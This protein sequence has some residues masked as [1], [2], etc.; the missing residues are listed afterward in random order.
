VCVTFP[1]K[2]LSM[3]LSQEATNA[4]IAKGLCI[5]YRCRRRAR[6]YRKRCHTC[7]SR[8]ERMKDPVY[9]AFENLK[10][11]A[12]KRGIQFLLTRLQF[13]EFCI[14]TGYLDKKGKEP[15]SLTV[16]RWPDTKGPYSKDNIRALGYYD[17]ISHRY[18]APPVDDFDPNAPFG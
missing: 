10:S 3:V 11:S 5:S 12:R 2:Y 1:H 16:D 8:I 15:N 4:K 18:E 14:K 17:N 7:L 13:E 6:K 9:Y